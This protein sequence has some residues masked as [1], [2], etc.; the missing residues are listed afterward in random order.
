MGFQFYIHTL[1]INIDFTP[2]HFVINF[3]KSFQIKINSKN[4]LI[5]IYANCFE[6]K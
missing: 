2:L 5:G 1:I 4:I 3:N 6:A